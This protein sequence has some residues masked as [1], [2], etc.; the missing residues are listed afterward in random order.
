MVSCSS[1]YTKTTTRHKK[2]YYF[3]FP[4]PTFHPNIFNNMNVIKSRKELEKDLFDVE[5]Y[6]SKRR[7]YEEILE[8]KKKKKRQQSNSKTDS[9]IKFGEYDKESNVL[10]VGSKKRSRRKEDDGAMQDGSDDDEDDNE[11]EEDEEDNM[12]MDEHMNEYEED[13][14]VMEEEDVDMETSN[15]G[16]KLPGRTNAKTA[17][18]NKDD[19]LEYDLFHLMAFDKHPIN[20]K[21][22]E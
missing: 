8:R 20:K 3:K 11:E 9:I 2:H 16:D 21:R 4:F 6:D 18:V 10:S 14:E 13:G 12:S 7:Q 5:G 19:D 17:V 15:E 1:S 22:Y